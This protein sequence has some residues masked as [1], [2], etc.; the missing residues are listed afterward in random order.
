MKFTAVLAT[1]ATISLSA[2]AATAATYSAFDLGLIADGSARSHSFSVSE[3]GE[4]TDIEIEIGFSTCGA[5][6]A[7]A[8]GPCAGGG[9][10]YNAELGLELISA[11][12]TTVALVRQGTYTGVASGA[13]TVL[14][15]DTA[16][17]RV[18]GNPF[19]GSFR[20]VE[21]LSSLIGENPLGQWALR[22]S[23]GLPVDPKRLDSFELNFSLKD[24]AISPVPLPASMGL[25]VSAAMGLAW[26]RRRRSKLG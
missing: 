15:S 14:F 12:G 19:S 21:S 24:A 1:V 2:A 18:G 23:D 25:M 17:N 4:I 9:N 16:D 3:S 22:I 8:T 5:R 20:P 13:F 11:A 26:L 10:P 6:Y 7:S